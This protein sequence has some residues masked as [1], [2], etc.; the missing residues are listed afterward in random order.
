MV[1]AGGREICCDL[2]FTESKSGM[3]NCSIAVIE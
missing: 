1:N 2:S 3:F